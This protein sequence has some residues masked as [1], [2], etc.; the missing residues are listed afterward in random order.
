LRHGAEL[1]GLESVIAWAADAEGV[2]VDTNQ[3]TYR[4]G[5]VIFTAGAWSGSLLSDLGSEL[6]VT[7]QVLAWFAPQQHELFA[8]GTFP[9]WF[10]ETELE[11]NANH[12]GS[13]D[14]YYGFP[15][16]S[17]SV[18]FKVALHQKSEP[19]DPSQPDREIRDTDLANLSQFLAD[20]IPLAAGPPLAA[21]VC[22]YTYS[23]DSHFIVDR[24]PV[25]ARVT[26][27]CGFSGHGF[28]FSAVLGEA[29]ADLA[30]RGETEL[31][32]EFLRLDRFRGGSR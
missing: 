8:L 7:R 18:G 3:A 13:G 11:T 30:T 29:L 26:L 14:G 22:F 21:E 16:F 25:H 4:A 6:S 1:H 27:A 28:K 32:I 20:H 10:V 31:P 15:I 2:T 17:G 24:H 5:H 9:V 19:V 12:R 23:P